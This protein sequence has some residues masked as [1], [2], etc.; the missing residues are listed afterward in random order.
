MDPAVWISILVGVVVLSIVIWV[1]LI[2]TSIRVDPGTLALLLK[3]GRATGRALEPGRHFIEPWRKVMVQ[4]YP[5]RELAFVAGG[6]ASG[7]PRVDATDTPLRLHLGDKTFAEVSYTVRCQLDTGKLKSV[8]NQFGPEGIWSALRDTTRKSLIAEAG[9]SK[10]TVDDVFGGKYSALEQRLGKALGK[11]L[12]DI[13]FE[14]KMFN[15]REIDLG[16]TGEVI[17]STLRA[18]AELEREQ[19]FATVRKARLENDASMR[20]LLAD[21]DGDVMLRYRQIEALAQILQ[22]WGGDRAI[23]AALTT[24]LTMP[25]PSASTTS[26]QESAGTAT[27]HEADGASE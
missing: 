24:P 27:Q 9:S 12:G 1:V 20:E 14:L 4:V 3:R 13:G 23:P 15:L 11:A 19:A 5:S 21:V 26:E 6:V 8:H 18:D 22:R 25:A 7:D 17:Q 2:E 16:E 10:V